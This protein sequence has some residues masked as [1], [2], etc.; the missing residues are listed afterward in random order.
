MMLCGKIEIARN[1]IGC[2]AEEILG[3][4]IE[5]VTWFFLIAYSEM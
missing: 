3:Q 1:E 5:Q 2:V 4:S